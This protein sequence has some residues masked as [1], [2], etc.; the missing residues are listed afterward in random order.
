[1]DARTSRNSVAFASLAL[2]VLALTAFPI[3]ARKR[4]STSQQSTGDAVADAARKAREEKKK[5]TP[6]PK[7]VYTD[8][9]LN[10][11]TS[12]SGPAPGDASTAARTQQGQGKDADANG[13][14]AAGKTPDRQ[15]SP[16]AKW[17]KQFKEAYAGL[18]RAETELSVL[19]REDNKAQLQYYPDPQKALA[20]Q[21]T[22]KEINEKDAKIA[23]K[24][25]EIEQIK[26]RIADMED[27]LRKSGGD[28]GWAA[29]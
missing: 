19:Q 15:E 3:L 9:D 18:D 10:H 24:K 17:R 7:K 2:A 6:K 1:M 21:Y 23:A 26:Q 16:E 11:S 29:P 4:Q 28:P 20:E 14:D 12:G 8:D 13:K 27:A 5:D 25:K 22:R